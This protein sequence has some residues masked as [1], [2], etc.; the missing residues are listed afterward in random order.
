MTTDCLHPATFMD[1]DMV[2][3]IRGPGRAQSTVAEGAD[4]VMHLIDAPGTGRYFDGRR[5]R[6]PTR[7][8][9]TPRRERS[10]GN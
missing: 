10:C 9:T 5:S 2:R 4:A 1:T 6:P 7:R 8:P 3:E